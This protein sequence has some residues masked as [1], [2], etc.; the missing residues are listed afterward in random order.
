MVV[1]YRGR[2]IINH[3]AYTWWITGF[4]PDYLNVK[5][6]NL[7]VTFTVKFKNRTMYNAFFSQKRIGWKSNYSQMKGTYSF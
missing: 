5:A 4:N 3:S 2:T 6:Y 1:K 7:Y